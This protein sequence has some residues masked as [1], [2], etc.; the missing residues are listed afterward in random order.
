MINSNYKL[1]PKNKKSVI[2]KAVI[3]PLVAGIIIAAVAVG[4]R[5]GGYF[6]D[7]TDN[8]DIAYFDSKDKTSEIAQMEL[9]DDELSVID[10]FDYSLLDDGVCRTKGSPFGEIGVGY[11]L[12]LQNKIDSSNRQNITVVAADKS[13][14]YKYKYSFSANNE[15]EIFA[16]SCNVGK[17]FVLYFQNAD[18]CGFSSD[19]TALVYEEVAK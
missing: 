6:F 16:R 17:G 7:I 11:Y 8:S 14:E 18:D 15:D 19:Y 9:G 5:F 1:T 12:V 4:F 13:Y 2:T 3:F 10:G